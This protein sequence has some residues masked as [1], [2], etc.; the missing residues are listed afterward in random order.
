MLSILSHD[1]MRNLSELN[2]NLINISNRINVNGFLGA[3]E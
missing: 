1:E 3:R 2:F